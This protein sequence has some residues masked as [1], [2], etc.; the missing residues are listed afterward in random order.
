[1][2]VFRRDLTK[3]HRWFR[4]LQ[5]KEMELLDPTVRS[6]HERVQELLHDDFLEFG[7]TGRVYNKQMLLEM[8]EGEQHA[9]VSLREF[10]VRELSPD[11]A[12]VTYRTVGQS[13]KEARRSSVWIRQDGKWRMSFHQGTRISGTGY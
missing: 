10:A 13:G 2:S 4:E 3:S 7:S 11:T 9:P 8:L 6:D 1:M 12:L 5:S